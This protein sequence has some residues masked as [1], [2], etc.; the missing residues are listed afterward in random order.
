MY[1][2]VVNL[3]IYMYFVFTHSDHHCN[4]KRHSIHGLYDMFEK[5]RYL[6]SLKMSLI[7]NVEVQKNDES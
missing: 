3:A 1:L 4:F 5:E 6:D 2:I 7:D